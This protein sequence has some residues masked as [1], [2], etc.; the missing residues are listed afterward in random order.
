MSTPH[1]DQYWTA[2]DDWQINA[3]LL[4][5]TGTPFDLS[6]APEILWALVNASGAR[7]LDEADVIIT[8]TDAVAG[9]CEIEIPA[10][11]TSPLPGGRYSDVIRI[12]IGG[13]TSTLSY[14]DICVT[15][16]P[17]ASATATAS[18]LKLVS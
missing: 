6:D 5:E 15:A 1:L 4:D 10:S 8:V 3:T 11:V 18:K 17:W 16:D 9:Q 7:V 12:V 13:V 2:G 14:G